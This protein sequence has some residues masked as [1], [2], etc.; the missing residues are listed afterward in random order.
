[1]SFDDCACSGKTLMRLLRPAVLRVLTDGPLHGYV[2]A[3]R[4]G[5]LVMFRDQPA[6]AT[7]LYRALKD[8]EKEGLLTSEWDTGESGPARRRY[9]V[10]ARGRKCLEQWKETLTAY[11][12]AIAD[13]LAWMGRK[14]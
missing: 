2:I 14:S 13:M 1:M 8:M 5:E 7:G 4:L 12:N 3:Q 10:T 6:D 11:G 9:Q